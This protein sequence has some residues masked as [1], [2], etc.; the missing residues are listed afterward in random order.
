[1]SKLLSEAERQQLLA[2][3]TAA[4]NSLSAMLSDLRRRYA[5]K[6]PV[7]KAAAKAERQL[8]Q[9]KRELE[10]MDLQKTGKEA[11]PIVKRAGTAVDF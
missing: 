7:M 3:L 9:L 10:K 8:F 6:L 4:H 11:L 1:M 5:A 2:E